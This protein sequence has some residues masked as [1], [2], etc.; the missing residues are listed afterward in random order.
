MK[1]F[2]EKNIPILII[3]TGLLFA[4]LA[5]F[6]FTRPAFHTA[7]QFNN[8]GAIGDTIGGITGPILNFVGLLLVYLSFK[9]QFN[10]NKSQFDRI[11]K[12]RN[13][14]L[15]LRLLEDFKKHNSAPDFEAIKSNIIASMYSNIGSYNQDMGLVK[16]GSITAEDLHKKERE[17]FE[18]ILRQEYYGSEFNSL[19]FL[20]SQILNKIETLQ[21]YHEEK[22]YLE[23]SF[24]YLLF[25]K[26]NH[27]EFSELLNFLNNEYSE[28]GT[29][30][31]NNDYIKNV[32]LKT[33]FFIKMNHL[34][35]YMIRRKIH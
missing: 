14:E 29:V 8:T 6:F 9:Q 18:R 4:L 28:I 26:F 13:F 25:D 31:V 15:T 22:E 2:S 10:A 7:L 5:P 32:T 19:L 20:A 16:Y 12:E 24:D 33:N 3:A 21:F 1:L 30:I 23:A 34:N 11:D 27:S 35:S 17:Q